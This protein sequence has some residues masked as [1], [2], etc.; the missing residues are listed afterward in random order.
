MTFERISSEMYTKFVQAHPKKNWPVEQTFAWGEFQDKIPGRHNIGTFLLKSDNDSP[1]AIASLL[2]F[3]MSGYSYVWINNG[4]IILDDTADSNA[5]VQTLRTIVATAVPAK[6][7]FIRCTF[8]QKPTTAMPAFSK[9]LLEKTTIVDLTQDFDVILSKMP[10]GT[11][12]GMRKATKNAITIKEIPAAQ[13]AADFAKVYQPIMVETAGRDGFSAHP[14]N[15]YEAMLTTLGNAVRFFVAEQDGAP[16]A[17]AINTAHNKKGIYYYGASNKAA[18]DVMAPYLL[19]I[20]AMKAFKSEGITS[21]DFLGIG[22][23]NFPGLEGVTQF[24]LRFGGDVISYQPVYDIP[25]RP[26]LYSLWKTAQ[27][28]RRALH[29]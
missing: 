21:Y 4:P 27:K 13:A 16:I 7:L 14:A 1:V 9:S 6:P 8:P 19:H 3:E 28:L 12:R 15:T 29:R 5:I 26:A 25:L 22:S 10:Y 23:P 2:F 18:R 20:E 24:K 11:R 17:W